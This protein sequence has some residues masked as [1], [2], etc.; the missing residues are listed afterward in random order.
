MTYAIVFRTGEES[1]IIDKETPRVL[2]PK[3]P[4]ATNICTC[5]YLN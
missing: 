3:L 2:K 1:D 5:T 4:G